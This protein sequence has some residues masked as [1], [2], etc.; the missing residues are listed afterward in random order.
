MYIDPKARQIAQIKQNS[1]KKR[2]S[3]AEKGVFA[4]LMAG[5]A[6][7]A[8]DA[9]RADS[10]QSLQSL[11]ALDGLLALQEIPDALH[12][13]KR[14]LRQGHAVLD[15]LEQLRTA[16]LCG[17]ITHQQLSTLRERMR[18][19]RHIPTDPHLRELLQDIELR[20]AVELAKFERDAAYRDPTDEV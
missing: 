15:G 9:P 12:D 14:A 2:A 20:A 8:E 19:L 7:H 5:G 18:S 4:A 16:I 1:A 10:G 13:R 6:E 11:S 3:G 17:D